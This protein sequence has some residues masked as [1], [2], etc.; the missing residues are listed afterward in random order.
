MQKEKMFFLSILWR[1]GVDERSTIDDLTCFEQNKL[2]PSSSA[3]LAQLD[4]RHESNVN[5]ELYDEMVISRSGE[6]IAR[7]ECVEEIFRTT[8]VTMWNWDQL[9]GERK[10]EKQTTAL[11]FG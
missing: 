4:H 1:L 8:Q 3:V 7:Q 9:I 11:T 5:F 10:K 6:L 2:L